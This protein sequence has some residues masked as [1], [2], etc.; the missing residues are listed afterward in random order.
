MTGWETNLFQQQGG[1]TKAF[2]KTNPALRPPALA[3]GVCYTEA[4]KEGY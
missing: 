1:T 3:C 4:I 2:I